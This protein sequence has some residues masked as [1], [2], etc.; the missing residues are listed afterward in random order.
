[1]PVP[2]LFNFDQ[3]TAA[4]ILGAMITPAVLI[5]ASGTLTLSTTNRLGRVVDRIRELQE[6]A[7]GMTPDATDP[8]SLEKRALITDQLGWLTIRL[9]MLQT[10]VTGL[11]VAIGLLV[12]T[13][14]AI[15]LSASAKWTLM[16][17]PVAI[18]LCGAS[19][20]FLAT[21]RLVREARLAVRSTLVEVEYVKR[22]I[23]R[24]TGLTDLPA[25]KEDLAGL[26]PGSRL[27]RKLLRP[28]PPNPPDGGVS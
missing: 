5:S 18:G 10:A 12:G 14:I 26:L 24:R 20:L 9:Q 8:E 3:S 6:V 2:F 27:L 15:G 23:A 25:A 19:S 16:W 22:V 11:F 17:V 7:E 21:V 28:E 13:S 1:M 4:D